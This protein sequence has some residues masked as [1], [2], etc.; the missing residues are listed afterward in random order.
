MPRKWS[1]IASLGSLTTRISSS[2]V[3]QR[4]KGAFQAEG[5][6][7]SS[8]RQLHLDNAG[9][10]VDAMSQLKGAAM[11]VGQSISVL[12]DSLELSDEVQ[13]LFSRLNDSAEP[14]PFEKIE[15]VLEQ[16]YERPLYEIFA[17][18]DP[19][20][21][22]TAS[23]AQAHAGRLLNGKSVVV[24]VL[25]EG[26]EDSVETDLM[27]LKSI[28][29]AGRLLKRSR[30]EIDLIFDEIKARLMEELDYENE[31]ENLRRF[32]PFLAQIE[33]VQSPLP[34]DEL[35][36][37][38]VL[39]MDRLMGMNLDR[40]CESATPEAK[41][42]AGDLL[43][44]IFHETA[45]V[46]RAVHAD[47]HGGNFLFR[48]DGS[49]SLIDFG[50]VK[51]L[52]SRFMHDY[53]NLANGVIDDDYDAM[54]SAAKSMGMLTSESTETAQALWNFAKVVRAP[55]EDPSFV[56]GGEADRLAAGIRSEGKALIP[57]TDIQP[58]RDV[59]FLH[60]TLLGTYSM[61]CKFKHTANYDAVRRHY[62]TI[63]IEVEQ[64]IREDLGWI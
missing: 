53:S 49:V 43:T 54:V 18:L 63:A 20:P 3:G 52:S 25:H 31:A 39:V 9:R 41:Q 2:Y 55:F 15:K 57:F 47:P 37:D 28:L 48:S 23:L 10:I 58:P 50:C 62:A 5:E 22:G 14:I 13:S 26:V 35:C 46:F 8:L 56:C 40:F 7:V 33:G 30:E 45:Y 1:R 51:R 64:G 38:R 21:L 4:I 36:T 6:R 59:I 32:H 24:K 11:K 12:A 29:L 19:E 17:E 44:T 16:Q 34:I 60:R 42:R 61:L 27:A